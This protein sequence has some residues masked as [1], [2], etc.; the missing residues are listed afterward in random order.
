ML[1]AQQGGLDVFKA[2]SEAD[3]LQWRQL[4]VTKIRDA[5]AA[6]DR[7]GVVVGHFMFW[8][9]DDAS[10]QIVL[11][12][13]DWDTFTHILYLDVP[14][15]LIE[16]RRRDDSQR[17]RRAV[18]P[19]HL[20]RW[21]EAEKAGLRRLCGEHGILFCCVS[22]G[23]ALLGKVTSLLHDFRV[24]NEVY[25]HAKAVVRLE[26]IFAGRK[27]LETALV[28][29]GD[30]TLIAEDTGE[31]FAKSSGQQTRPR[32]IFS[33]PLGYSY[34]AFRQA[35]L[36]Y[37]EAG[38][39]RE[40]KRLC[41]RVASEVKIHPDFLSL[42]DKA[43]EEKHVGA[44]VITSGLGYLWEII[45]EMHDLHRSVQVIG[46]GRV[47]D[48]FVVT[49]AVKARLAEHLG[50]LYKCH[51]WAFG[52]SPLDLPMLRQA[53]EA[54][55]VVRE[56]A[57]RSK[58]MDKALLEA[59][60]THGLHARQLLLPG[61]VVPRLDVAKLPVVQL[62]EAVLNSVFGHGI[63]RD[64]PLQVIHESESN[65]VK[66]LT[67]PT[68]DAKI[69]GPGLREAHRHVG[70]YLALRCLS[71][72]VGVEEHPIPHVQGHQTSGFRLRDAHKTCI[73]ALMRGGEPMAMGVSDVVPEAMFLHATDPKDVTACHLEGQS[74][75]FLVDS[76]VN[77]GASVVRFYERIRGLK[78]TIRTVVVAG[79][80]Q[81]QCVSNGG[82]L[83]ALGRD[84]FFDVVALRLSNNA[85]TGQGGTDTGNR[86]FNTTHLP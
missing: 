76:V 17:S 70:R 3:K 55:V 63:R 62:D 8:D 14:T 38:D 46:G 37:E 73:V 80:V 52:D 12:E 72:V 75:V 21:Q 44:V 31:L 45:L 86:L 67:T 65:A 5:C 22:P 2:S 9:E 16:Q 74:T 18:S 53:D 56:E 20:H 48:N 51:V 66:M 71:E 33:G 13:S 27:H 34:T 49:A 69:R 79:V 29:D 82:L 64:G 77:S 54:I 7:V 25:N 50:G 78:A 23:P 85:F 57:L 4:A 59:I 61:D 84:A 35:M 40:F 32:D 1:T 10:G 41:Y 15:E 36:L 11:T 43:A 81:A 60:D 39:A 26:E 6:S 68:R 28:L 83:H 42:L 30:R 24:H 58:S 19:D 47:A